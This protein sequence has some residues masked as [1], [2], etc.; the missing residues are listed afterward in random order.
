MSMSMNMKTRDNRFL[1]N[2]DR[3]LIR[4]NDVVKQDRY[5]YLK[6]KYEYE[7]DEQQKKNIQKTY[8]LTSQVH[9]RQEGYMTLVLT[10]TNY[11][12][13]NKQTYAYSSKSK[14]TKES[15][16]CFWWIQLS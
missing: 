13:E 4:L 7:T 8:G 12:D 3:L 2:M 15:E 1:S 11:T 6:L 14:S 9:N 5:Q 10:L 16:E